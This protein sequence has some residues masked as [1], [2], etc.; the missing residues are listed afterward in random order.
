MGAA[1]KIVFF[2]LS[3]IIISIVGRQNSKKLFSKDS[4]IITA[5]QGEKIL[6]FDSC[7]LFFQA[8]TLSNILNCWL[9]GS[10]SGFWLFFWVCTKSSKLKTCLAEKVVSCLVQV[11]GGRGK[12]LAVGGS[13]HL[14]PAKVSGLV[15]WVTW[16][17]CCCWGCFF[18]DLMGSE[19]H[20]EAR[21]LGFDPGENLGFWGVLKPSEVGEGVLLR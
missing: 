1:S 8:C 9:K 6:C 11:V 18:L 2:F 12:E 19:A 7:F 21:V 17:C 5:I 3:V 14:A 20:L 4:W 16:A 13:R 10:R 15:L